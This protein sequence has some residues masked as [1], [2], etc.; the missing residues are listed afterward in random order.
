MPYAAADTPLRF[1]RHCR[2]AARHLFRSYIDAAFDSI[3]SLPLSHAAMP[4]AYT[5]L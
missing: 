3:F 5:L 1:L 2:A 4:N